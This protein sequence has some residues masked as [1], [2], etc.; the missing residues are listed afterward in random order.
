MTHNL[1]TDHCGARLCRAATSQAN[2]ILETSM[3]IID[4]KIEAYAEIHS[5]R[6]SN[7]VAEIHQWT[8][9]NC[10]E[11]Q[12]LSGELQI[13]VLRLLARSIGAKRVLEIGMFTGY[14][15]LAVAEVLPEHGELITLDIE[16][17]REHIARGFFDRSPHGG[18]IL[19]HIGHALQVLPTL[20]GPFDMVYI[21]ADKANYVRY[22]EAVMPM[23]ARGGLVVADNVLWSSEVLN[24]E[25]DNAIAL[26]MFNQ[27]VQ[28][29][30]RVT[31][32]LMPI[33]D[34]L[35]VARK[36]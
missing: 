22:Y 21:D 31:N 16:A 24:P 11:S 3:N 18:K 13:A 10:D 32:L 8:V 30:A 28:N 23:V 25:S 17:E 36:I 7:L 35:M 4:P 5:E 29:D 26:N 14:S 27:H 20:D 33:R 9:A 1:V 15:A 2:S 19:I 34:G 6:S 12:M